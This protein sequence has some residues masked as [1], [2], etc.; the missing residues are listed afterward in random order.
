M[1][2]IN[3]VIY[4]NCFLSPSLYKRIYI[5]FIYIGKNHLNTVILVLFITQEKDVRQEPAG[6]SAFPAHSTGKHRK[7]TG[8]WKQYSSR[9]FL[10]FFPMISDRFLQENTGNSQ[11]FTGK[12]SEKL[13]AGILLPF[14][15]LSRGIWRLFRI[16]PAGSHRIR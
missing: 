3:N 5:V 11:E 12:K 7:H 8:R 14:P 9:N 2:V 10:G 15:I 6:S 16:F 4:V 13:P 1:G